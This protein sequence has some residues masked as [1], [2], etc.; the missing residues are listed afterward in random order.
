MRSRESVMKFYSMGLG[1][2]TAVTLAACAQ[3]GKQ[4]PLEE[5]AAH[6]LSEGKSAV[7]AREA[8]WMQLGDR[9]LNTL[10]DRAV[11]NSPDLKAAKS[12]LAQAQAQLGASDAADKTRIG[13][14]VLGTGVYSVPKPKFSA[15]DTDHTLLLANAALQGSWSFDFW[16]KNREAL[17]AALGRRQAA[18]YE[19]RQVRLELAR[20][21]A[22]QYFTWQALAEQAALLERR[23]D[24]AEK[25]EQLV[26]RRI[27]G[28]L[29]P[30]ESLYRFEMAARQLELEQSELDRN[31]TKVRHALAA[32]TGQNP[33]A[34]A[35]FSPSKMGEPPLLPVDKIHADL[36]ASRP[37]IAVQKALLSS[38]G[39]AVKSVQAEFY[40]DI[41]LKLLAGLAH[42][43]AFDVVRGGNSGMLGVLPALNLPIFTSGALQSRLAG[44]RA[45]YNEQVALYDQTVL[46]AMRSAADAVSDYQL[47][48]KQQPVWKKLNAT[49]KQ[50]ALSSKSRVRA[51]LDN[52]LDSLEKQDQSIKLEMQTV[53]YR[54]QL[55][56]AWSNV[57]AQLGG[58]FRHDDR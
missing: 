23:I 15:G 29:M 3:F 8:W 52:G 4:A 26:K 51:G 1:L 22:A 48:K 42:I 13:L 33:Y 2:V 28:K 11:Q 49:A 6:S 38:R 7:Y 19:T 25:K 37:D 35:T 32:L 55:L 50:A 12:R 47:L 18:L 40:P 9:K 27:N 16:G 57:H 41:E 14:S 43:D 58:G 20:A 10:I 17:A 45:E 46:T 36:L 5:P 30:S 44:K 34:L 24:L 31:L 39:H 56:T 54:S 53:Q 21:V